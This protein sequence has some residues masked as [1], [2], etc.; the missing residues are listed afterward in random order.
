VFFRRRHQPRRPPP[1]KIR[2]GRPAPAMGPGTAAGV[3]IPKTASNVLETEA[4][5]TAGAVS[6][7][8]SPS[9]L[10]ETGDKKLSDIGV[11]VAPRKAVSVNVKT[12]EAMPAAPLAGNVYW[13][14]TALEV[15]SA[16]T[17]IGAGVRLSKPNSVCDAD[18]TTLFGPC[19]ALFPNPEGTNPN[20]GSKKVNPATKK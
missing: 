8:T 4:T 6:V 5:P 16:V 19:G 18:M 11:M 15:K 1:A 7:R 10:L 13:S 20:A 12:P 9:K 14:V 2:P 3:A 17:K